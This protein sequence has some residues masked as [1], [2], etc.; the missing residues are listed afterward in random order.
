MSELRF[1]ILGAAKI[2]PAALIAPARQCDG[3]RVVAVAARDRARAERFAEEH[4]IPEVS[5]SYAELV[6]RADIDCVYNALPPSGHAPWSIRALEAGKH[7]LCEKPF[8]LNAAEAQQMVDTAH[9]AGRVLCEAFHDRYHPLAARVLEVVGGGTLG[10]LREVT[11]RFTVPIPD[12]RDLRYQL[13][14]GGGATMDLG[15]YPI[16]QAMMVVGEKPR[17]VSAE[18]REGPA[19]IDVEMH[20]R[21]AFPGGVTGRIHCGMFEGVEVGLSLEVVGSAGTL[22]VQNPIHPYAG[23]ELCITTAAG[24]QTSQVEGD[25][26]YRHQLDSFRAAVLM[27][28]ALPTGGRDAVDTMAVID[29]VYAT[30]GLP[31]RGAVQGRN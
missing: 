7:V 6:E 2:A 9:S 3:V 29:A 18:A 14:L 31:P 20:A 12:T 25:T 16:H 27:G 30:A 4:G 22:T 19:G 17:V 8:C 11:G 24:S 1:G 10:A 28:E 21:L 26:T 5:A 23:H 15:C 13:E